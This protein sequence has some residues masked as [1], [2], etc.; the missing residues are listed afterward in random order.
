MI[1]K[2]WKNIESKIAKFFGTTRTPRSG[3]N[4]K[5]TRSDTLH[6]ELFIEVKYRETMSIGQLFRR[7][8]ELA[9]KENKIPVVVVQEKYDKPLIVCKLEDIKTI[10]DYL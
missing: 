6:P 7:T 3:G 2:T 1:K 10:G 5:Q 8:E 9:K 4:S